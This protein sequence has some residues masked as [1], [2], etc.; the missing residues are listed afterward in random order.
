[1]PR[2]LKSSTPPPARAAR[3]TLRL[4]EAATLL[5]LSRSTLRHHVKAGTLKATRAPGKYGEEYRIRPAVL[6]VFALE[7]FGIS[8]EDSDFEALPMAEGVTT[9]SKPS[10][11]VS[12]LAESERG[13][14]ERLI[15]ATEEA[16]RYKALCEV[17]EST[18]RE[19]AEAEAQYKDQIA[20][21]L[22]EKVA[23]QERLEALEARG[24][25]GRLFRR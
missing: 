4:A 12:P 9:I 17:S 24:L 10:A 7:T 14:Y 19:A 13:L 3:D 25:W 5:D 18:R 23:L 11:I 20:E 16:T 6:K 22:Q 1:M 8:L 15:A 2:Q 21:L